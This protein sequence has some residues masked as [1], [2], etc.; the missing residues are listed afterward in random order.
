R[1]ERTWFGKRFPQ[2]RARSRWGPCSPALIRSSGT[3]SLPQAVEARIGDR[4]LLA[5]ALGHAK[6]HTYSLGHRRSSSH[7]T[8]PS[9]DAGLTPRRKTSPSLRVRRPTMAMYLWTK[10]EIYEQK[11]RRERGA[12]QASVQE[13]GAAGARSAPG[14]DA[15]VLARGHA[16]VAPGRGRQS[17]R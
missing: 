13:G 16:D 5:P 4:T 17:P 2:G 8:P 12:R 1:R 6:R 14:E 3:R 9:H 10:S 7:Q 15:A 11:V